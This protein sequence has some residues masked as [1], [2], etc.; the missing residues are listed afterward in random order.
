MTERST[1]T[2]SACDGFAVVPGELLGHADEAERIGGQLRGDRATVDGIHLDRAAFGELCQLL[3]E[4]L[5][6]LASAI[7]GATGALADSLAENAVQ[8]REAAALY[9]DGDSCA[10]ESLHRL[11]LP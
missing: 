3:P 2:T 6:P 11:E 1:T 10:A 5:A 8:L 9:G 7:A 4:A